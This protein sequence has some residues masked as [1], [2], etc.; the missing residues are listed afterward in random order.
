MIIKTA[1]ASARWNLLSYYLY[2]MMLENVLRLLESLN[3]ADVLN[4]VF[5]HCIDTQM[6]N[7]N[8]ELKSVECEYCRPGHFSSSLEII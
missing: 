2:I 7:E 8:Q 5:I 3:M 4:Y 6:I 1:E